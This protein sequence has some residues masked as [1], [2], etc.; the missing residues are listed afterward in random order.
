MPL[1]V[2]GAAH[3]PER[4]L[5]ESF[6]PAEEVYLIRYTGQ[7]FRDYEC[8]PGTFCLLASVAACFAED[9]SACLWNVAIFTPEV[10]AHV[11]A[12]ARSRSASARS[13][14]KANKRAVSTSAL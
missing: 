4:F 6:G 10:R 2:Y 12:L 13:A 1:D 7:V 8:G 14:G 9:V 3:E 5:P 11:R